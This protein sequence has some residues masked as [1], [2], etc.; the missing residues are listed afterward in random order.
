LKANKLRNKTHVAIQEL[1]TFVI[2]HYNI[3][4]NISDIEI[5]FNYNC[6]MNELEQSQI[7]AQSQYLSK[8]TLV[9]NH[10]WV[11]DPQTELERME[12]EQME[13]NEQFPSIGEGLNDRSEDNKAR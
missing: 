3:K 13:Y 6:M 5:V 8:E 10:P 7:G 2:Q 12:A 1:L 4:A 9:T 11:H